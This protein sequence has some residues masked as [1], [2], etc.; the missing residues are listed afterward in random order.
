M[1]TD[2]HDLIQRYISGT[3]SDADAKTLEQQLESDAALRDWYLDAVNLDSALEVTAESAELA[4]SLPLP[5]SVRALSPAPQLAW[6]SLALAA[7]VVIAATIA[8]RWLWPSGVETPWVKLTATTNARWADTTTELSLNAGDEPSGML[9]LLDGRAEFATRSG[10]VVA[11]EAPT[12]MRFDAPAS[13]YVESGKVV[14][15]C[16]T[17]NSRLT[18]HTAQTQVVDLGTEFAVE[19]RGDSCTRVAVFSGE[20]KVASTVLKQGDGVEVRSK[21]VTVLSPELLAEMQRSREAAPLVPSSQSNRLTNGQFDNPPGKIAWGMLSAFARVEDGELR[22]SARGH[23]SWP[24]A[25]Q[26]IWQSDLPDQVVSAR[27]KA[28]QPSDDALVDSQCAVLKLSFVGE[29]GVEFA[30]A[31]RHFQFAGDA[32]N[33]VQEAQVAA[34]APPGTKG[35]N[36]QLMLNARGE[37]RGSV[38]FDDASLTIGDAAAKTEAPAR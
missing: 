30:Y 3:I 35:V 32:V 13:L 28:R 36:V 26:I 5:A 8:W 29:R 9:R 6:R 20:V 38:I 16:P 31:S 10:A 14:C 7:A 19:A 12:A 15:R 2:W 27:V 33:V 37:K 34:I 18:V 25:R 22:I 11:I 24:N 23:Q 1:N 21:G 4:L 17:P